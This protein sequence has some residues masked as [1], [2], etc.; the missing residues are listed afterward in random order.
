MLALRLLWTWAMSL[1]LFSLASSVMF[2]I[3]AFTSP[4]F[5]AELVKALP[6]CYITEDTFDLQMQETGHPK[7]LVFPPDLARRFI[8]GWNATIEGHREPL[9]TDGVILYDNPHA[10]SYR[11]AFLKGNCLV[12]SLDLQQDGFWAVIKASDDTK[13]KI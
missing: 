10:P 7:L 12:D 5:P 11:I 8:V 9:S 2:V 13:W 6:K 3:W 1:A 4:A